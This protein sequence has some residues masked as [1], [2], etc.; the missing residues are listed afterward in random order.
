MAGAGAGPAGAHRVARFS[1]KVQWPTLTRKQVA[2]FWSKVDRSGDG[3]WLWTAGRYK[4]G[5]GMF[6][7]G[8]F[9]DGR[10]DVRHAHRLAY[11]L[12]HGDVP[13]GLVVKHACDNPP[14]CNPAHLS[15]GTQADNLREMR[16][17]GRDRKAIGPRTYPVAALVEALASERRGHITAVARKHGIAPKTLMGGVRRHRA[18]QSSLPQ[19]QGQ[20]FKLFT[21]PEQHLALVVDHGLEPLDEPAQLVGGQV[22][23]V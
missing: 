14:C 18:R 19:L 23:E 4:H 2:R 1:P 11:E 20:S 7:A 9:R 8:R 21:A 6:H 16:E 13:D 17:R 15:V 10:Q 12:T 5:Y 3:C 22:G